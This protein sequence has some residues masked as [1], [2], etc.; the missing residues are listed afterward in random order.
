MTRSS[1]KDRTAAPTALPDRQE[2]GELAEIF[3][4]LGDPTRVRIIFSILGQERSVGE[5]AA[6]L[7][8]SEPS[9]SQHLRRLRALRVVRLRR[10]GRHRFYRLDDDH[11]GTLLA[12]CLDHLRDERS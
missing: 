1:A 2:V 8:L 4:A 11:I 10:A 6:H 7:E 9:V 3:S 5:I 12:I